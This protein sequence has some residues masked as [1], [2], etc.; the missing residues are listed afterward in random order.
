MTSG[1]ARQAEIFAWLV[2]QLDD[3]AAE[4]SMGA[5]GAIEGFRPAAGEDRVVTRA[6]SWASAVA[7]GGGLRLDAVS[8]LQPVAFEIL[9]SAAGSWNHAVALCLPAGRKLSNGRPPMTE[10]G[11]D[12]D[13]LRAEDRSAI[14][15]DLGLANAQAEILLRTADAELIRRL[16]AAGG[17]P[18]LE[19]DEA[20]LGAIG[21]MAHDRIV[22]T[23]LG[24]LE[25]SARAPTKAA[26]GLDAL[27]PGL[28]PRL[29]ASSMTHPSTSPIPA[30]LV[31]FGYLFPP[32]P[33]RQAPLSPMPFDLDRHRA[34]QA[35]LQR[36]GL[37]GLNRLK[38]AVNAA[39]DRNEPPD[40]FPEPNGRFEAA[41]LRVTLRQRRLTGGSRHL[42]AWCERFD[43][44][45]S[46]HRHGQDGAS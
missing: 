9:S 34:F 37:P 43:R 14:L 2:A 10:L 40:L 15:F 12:S 28:V 38:A 25:V 36:F 29:L 44:A 30:G 17:R 19:A 27:F 22:V 23:P 1:A 6:P 7:S 3:P 4:W 13:A 16:R 33:A 11:A 46:R 24:R 39:L 26:A 18:L 41:C 8:G 45:G 20:L 32:H 42:D 21:R 31:P 5:F 35:I